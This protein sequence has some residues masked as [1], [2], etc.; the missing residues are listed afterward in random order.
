M[1]SIVKLYK[2]KTI[3]T[4]LLEL[5]LHGV[6]DSFISVSCAAAGRTFLLEPLLWNLHQNSYQA[7]FQL[8][9]YHC[10]HMLPP[11]FSLLT[12]W[13]QLYSC[14]VLEN[15]NLKRIPW[16]QTLFGPKKPDTCFGISFSDSSGSSPSWSANNKWS[17]PVWFANG[18]SA[19]KVKILM[20]QDQLVYSSPLDGECGTI[21][22]PLHSDHS[23]LLSLPWLELSSNTLLSKLKELEPKRIQSLKW[24]SAALEESFT[25]LINMS[26]SFPKMP[27]SKL[28]FTTPLSAHQHGNHSTWSSDTQEDSPLLVPSDGSWCFSERDVSW[29]LLLTWLLCSSSQHTQMFNNHSFQHSLLLWLPTLSLPCSCLSSVS[30]ALLSSIALSWLRTHQIA[31]PLVQRA[32][33]LSLTL[34]TRLQYQRRKK[35]KPRNRRLSKTQSSD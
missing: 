18:T 10:C 24:L 11:C 26:S 3:E 27:S 17:L 30:H 21:V 13:Q 1:V 33:K 32:F 12:G 8:S 7:T 20:P 28:P 6:L 2:R 22:E 25:Y 29:A 31:L 35:T 23:A 15:Q 14:I 16:L 4:L 9:L 34:K 19:D 5:V